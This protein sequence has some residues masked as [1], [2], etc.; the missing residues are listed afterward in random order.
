MFDIFTSVKFK[1]LM[2]Q[3]VN[4]KIQG[5]CRKSRMTTFLKT[6]LKK[7]DDR[8]ID[9]YRV[10][11]NTEYNIKSKLIILKVISKLMMIRQLFCV[12]ISNILLY[13]IRTDGLTLIIKESYIH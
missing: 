11:A 9:K 5:I 2:R 4:I 3:L 8:T 6:K 1:F 12:K 10:A 13:C 7:S